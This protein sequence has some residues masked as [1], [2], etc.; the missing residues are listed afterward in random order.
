VVNGMEWCSRLMV[1]SSMIKFVASTLWDGFSAPNVLEKN[2]TCRVI[3]R[4]LHFANTG[5]MSGLSCWKH[6][7]Q[8]R[9]MQIFMTRRPVNCNKLIRKLRKERAD[10]F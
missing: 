8:T 3:D 4:V 7:H 5:K 1:K 10:V 2:E 6:L 9:G